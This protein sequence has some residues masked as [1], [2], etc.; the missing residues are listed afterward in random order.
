MAK[1][2]ADKIDFGAILMN[3]TNDDNKALDDLL[4]LND[5]FE[6]PTLKLSIYKNR[7]GKYKG[8]YLWCRADLGTCRVQPM[9]A[10]TYNYEIVNI[11]DL[12]I[13]TEDPGAF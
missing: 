7:R 11:E 10:T 12:K 9:F 3:V 6:R 2:I 1:S 4:S 13:I 8:I 5:G